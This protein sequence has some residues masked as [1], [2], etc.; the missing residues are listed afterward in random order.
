MGPISNRAAGSRGGHEGCPG[1]LEDA[2]ELA[3][4]PQGTTDAIQ[5]VGDDDR[6]EVPMNPSPWGRRDLAEDIRSGNARCS[7]SSSPDTSAVPR[8]PHVAD[9]G[10]LC[11]AGPAPFPR[12]PAGQESEPRH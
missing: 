11:A 2:R 6:F 7:R 10:I 9:A 3:K 1:L 8:L 5:L 4:A 12:Y